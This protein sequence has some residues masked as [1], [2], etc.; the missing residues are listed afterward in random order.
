MPLTGLVDD[1]ERAAAVW[2][3]LGMVCDPELD[4]PITDLGFVD[5]VRIDGNEV[6]VGFRLPTY[7][8]APNFAFMIASDIQERVAE[9]SWVERVHV[10]LRDHCVEEAITNGIALGR[11][12]EETFPG[13]ATGDLTHIRALFRRKAFMTRQ[14]QL[15][16]CLR[17][18]GWSADSLV[19]LTIQE[20]GGLTGLG[21]Q[22]HRLR[23]RYLAVRQELRLPSKGN[24]RA[25]T[26]AEGAPVAVE[27]FEAYVRTLRSCRMNME[28][29]THFCRGLLRVRYGILDPDGSGSRQPAAS[30]HSPVARLE[31]HKSP[32]AESGS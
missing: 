19:C 10:R 5:Q 8:C 7:W 16:D 20:L 24:Q 11:S 15:L 12:F 22:G 9:L 27:A 13:E 31:W 32:P 17:G 23:D 21:P 3:R 26:T 14:G 29:N 18:G 6:A 28:I 4:E 30:E 25:I 2:L 1:G